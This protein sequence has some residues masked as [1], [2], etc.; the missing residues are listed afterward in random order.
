MN[1]FKI[2]KKESDQDNFI[3][4]L[5]ESF[6]STDDVE[7]YASIAFARCLINSSDA[8]IDKPSIKYQPNF[9]EGG[10]PDFVIGIK[11]E[12]KDYLILL[13]DKIDAPINND[14]SAY[15]NYL[16]ENERLFCSR[17]GL[18]SIKLNPVYL[19]FKTGIITESDSLIA[20]NSGYRLIDATG[21]ANV[22][23][24]FSSHYLIKSFVEKIWF[25]DHELLVSFSNRKEQLFRWLATKLGKKFVFN[26]EDKSADF[27]IKDDKIFINVLIKSLITGQVKIRLLSTREINTAYLHDWKVV[28]TSKM[29][30]PVRGRGDLVLGNCEIIVLYNYLKK[31]FCSIEAIKLLWDFL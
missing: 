30:P 13:E 7:K 17:F 3:R 20:K 6:D 2:A 10:R 25:D 24:E 29:N 22:L 19:V 28:K 8:I 15:R 1:F 26:Q 5:L 16:V 9:N 31:C 18:N 11:T 14:L 27:Y 21:I 23:K 12:T 4:W